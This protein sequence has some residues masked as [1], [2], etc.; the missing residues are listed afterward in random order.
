[1]EQGAGSRVQSAEL[2]FRINYFGFIVLGA[3]CRSWGLGFG[4]WFGLQSLEIFSLWL[5]VGVWSLGFGVY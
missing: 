1:M 2:G 5:R 3:G 4:V